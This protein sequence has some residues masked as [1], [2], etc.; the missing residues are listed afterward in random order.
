MGR[1]FYTGY[2]GQCP[3]CP[4]QFRVTPSAAMGPAEGFEPPSYA[5]GERRATIALDGYI[6]HQLTNCS[7]LE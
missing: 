5:F 1:C 3:V 6:V 7:I 4:V 2:R